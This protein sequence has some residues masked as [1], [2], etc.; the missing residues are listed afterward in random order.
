MSSRLAI[1]GAS[2]A[3]GRALAH[4]AA[5]SGIGTISLARED[6]ATGDDEGLAAT[7]RRERVSAVVHLAGPTPARS[8]SDDALL[9]SASLTRTI[10]DAVRG[11]A[12]EIPLVLVSSA[13]VYGESRT[14]RIGEDH[15]LDGSSAYARGK[16]ESEQIVV[17]AELPGWILRVFNVVGPGQSGSLVNRLRDSHPDAPVPLRGPDDFIR[18]YV[19]VDDV[20][21]AIIASALSPSRLAAPLNVGRGIPVSNRDVVEEL[22]ARGIRPAVVHV[23]GP[24]SRSVADVALIARALSWKARR[25]PFD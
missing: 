20:A 15:P 10:V 25:S 18:D 5:R 21:E 13:A 3:I 14:A 6:L 9:G 24:P 4:A 17:A 11:T 22:S 16:R 23:D 1:T 2:G 19:H 7:M 8:T 12:R